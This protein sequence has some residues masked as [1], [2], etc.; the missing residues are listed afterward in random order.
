MFSV[1]PEDGL[2]YEVDP[3]RGTD[4]PPAPQPAVMPQ[5]CVVKLGRATYVSPA[6][7]PFDSPCCA[8]KD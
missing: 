6:P 7:V 1:Q 5:A 4:N 2:V 8:P 3:S